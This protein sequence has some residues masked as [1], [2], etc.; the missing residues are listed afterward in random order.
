MQR[1]SVS[2]GASGTHAIDHLRPYSRSYC[3]L[4]TRLAPVQSQLPHQPSPPQAPHGLAVLT[5]I[6]SGAGASVSV[7][8]F[9]GWTARVWG[10]VRSGE[11][12]MVTLDFVALLAY[13][14]TPLLYVLYL[15]WSQFAP[16]LPALPLQV[17]KRCLSCTLIGDCMGLRGRRPSR[18]KGGGVYCFSG[19]TDLGRH[20]TRSTPLFGNENSTI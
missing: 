15:A 6:L 13:F 2:A 1:A 7:S 5:L 3:P 18:A 11:F 9:L 16:A 10:P 19:G 4:R 20:P 12:Q 8:S 17:R 14:I